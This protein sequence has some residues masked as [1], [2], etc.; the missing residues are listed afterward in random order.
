MSEEI[1]MQSGIYKITC[2]LILGKSRMIFSV[3]YLIPRSP[4]REL[5]F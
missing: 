5:V 4:T 3:I 2:F 1:H